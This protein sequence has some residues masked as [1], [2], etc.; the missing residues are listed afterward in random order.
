MTIQRI[1]GGDAIWNVVLSL[2]KQLFLFLVSIIMLPGVSL[3]RVA[4]QGDVDVN[5]LSTV[6]WACEGTRRKQ[7]EAR[8]R[9]RIVI[10]KRILRGDSNAHREMC[11]Q[12]VF[13]RSFM[14]AY[15]SFYL[16]LTDVHG[17]GCRSSSMHKTTLK[18]LST[19]Y[20]LLTRSNL[21]ICHSEYSSIRSR[22]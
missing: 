3:K 18:Q 14:I 20:S 5:Y 10:N 8:A 9:R 11:V 2:L 17:C 12:G 22:Q 15:S 6:S 19:R 13:S 4:R 21:C 1:H 7:K 16:T